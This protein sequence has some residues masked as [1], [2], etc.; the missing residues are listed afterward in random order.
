MAGTVARKKARIPY[1]PRYRE[2]H[3]ILET[4]RFTV[5]VAHRRFG[6]TVLAINHMLKMAITCKKEAGSYAYVAPFRNQA[7]Q[8]SWDYLKR[9]TQFIPGRQVHEGDLC[10]ILPSGARMRIFGADN[11]DSLRGLYFDGVIMDEVAQM[12]RD[13]WEE[14]VQPALADRMG[15]A[16]FIG[17]PKGINL[18][19]ELFYKAKDLQDGGDKNWAALRYPVT[20]TN[21]LQAEEVERQRREMSANAFRQ[22]YM[23]DFTASSE[24]IL[25][26]LDD[27]LAASRRQYPPFE[28]ASMPVVFGVDVARYG[29]DK[30]CIFIRQGLVAEEPRLLSQQ[31]SVE[32]ANEL[33]GLILERN[34]AAVFVDA[35]QGQGVIDIVKRMVDVVV[36]VP[37]GSRA[38]KQEKFVN[39]RSEMWYSMRE[40]VRNGGK[41]PNNTDLLAEMSG[42]TYSFDSKGRILLEEKKDIKK[43][44][45]RSPDMADALALTFAEPILPNSLLNFNRGMVDTDPDVFSRYET[46]YVD[47][48]FRSTFE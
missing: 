35:G 16:L 8:V 23:C 10:I 5:L 31:D 43:R 42:P 41:I 26:T 38:L 3:E 21:V 6:K 32:V 9:Y 27:V 30:T 45:S 36:E 44:L 18:F 29:A 20:D 47:G 2:I 14:I 40:W 13:V 33:Y 24:D 17:T 4:H 12:R 19:S 39:R 28:Y 34:P 22:E 37:F 48:R 11:P 46:G 25:I 1:K 7:K 15:W